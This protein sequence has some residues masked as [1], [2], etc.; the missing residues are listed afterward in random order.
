MLSKEIKV[1]EVR[2]YVKDIWIEFC[3]PDETVCRVE[4]A[5]L[6]LVRTITNKGTYAVEIGQKW[7]E[8]IDDG[9]KVR[10]LSKDSPAFEKFKRE[11]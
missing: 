2:K 8:A 1:R 3:N 4:R 5:P 10:I 11:G 9:K 6:F 7:Y